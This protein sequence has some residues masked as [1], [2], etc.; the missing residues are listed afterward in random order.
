METPVYPIS[1]GIT[2]PLSVLWWRTDLQVTTGIHLEEVSHGSVTA[3][4][5]CGISCYNTIFGSLTSGSR[6]G[7][8]LTWR[9]ACR[10]R[11]LQALSAP[12]HS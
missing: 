3:D 5:I 12:A 2:L 6:G 4:E 10:Q 9:G 1:T 7:H 11:Q 8:T